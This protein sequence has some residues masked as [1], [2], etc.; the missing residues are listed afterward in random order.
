MGNKI[1]IIKKVEPNSIRTES[2]MVHRSSVNECVM[3]IVGFYSLIFI[4]VFS[5]SSRAQTQTQA[6]SNHV[7]PEAMNGIKIDQGDDQGIIKMSLPATELVERADLYFWEPKTIGNGA[8]GI[9]VLA[10]GINGNGKGYLENKQWRSFAEQHRLLLCGLSFSSKREPVAKSYSNAH[11]GAG[12]MLLRGLSCF[13]AG[14]EQQEIPILIYGFSGGARFSA[15]FVEGNSD[16]VVAWAAYAVGRWR[17]ARETESQPPGIVA[18]GEWDAVSYH[19]SLLYFQQGRKLGKPWTWLSLRET[20]H[21]QSAELEGFI[22]A[23][24]SEAIESKWGE[25]VADTSDQ[26]FYYDIDSQKVLTKEEV[27]VWP[28]FSTWLPPDKKI[29]ERWKEIHHP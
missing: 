1:M 21:A 24:F 27:E 23:F 19:A 7:K 25:N 2:F 10:P 3:R 28:I 13:T 5:F 18:C 14:K 16:R 9:L 20:G 26:G 29:Q 8:R 22:R 11:S 15:S 17:D 6:E 12:K 4:L